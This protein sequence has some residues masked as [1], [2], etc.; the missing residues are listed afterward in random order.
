[1]AAGD[2]LFGLPPLPEQDLPET[3]PTGTQWFREEDAE[4]FFGRGRETGMFYELVT[5]SSRPHPLKLFY[6]QSG[7]GKSSML[8][9]GLVLPVALVPVR[10]ATSGDSETSNHRDLDDRAGRSGTGRHPTLGVACA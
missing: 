6:G 1:M 4:L 5:L 10:C 7:V 8:A 9:A 3:P 2:P